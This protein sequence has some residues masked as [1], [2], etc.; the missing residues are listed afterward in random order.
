M[1]AARTEMPLRPGRSKAAEGAIV[2]SPFSMSRS[3]SIVRDVDRHRLGRAVARPIGA[4]DGNGIGPT[5]SVSGAL[6]TQIHGQ[7]PGDLPIGTCGSVARAV[8]R[9]VAGDGR[10]VA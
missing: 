9:L 10:D 2:R 5:A 7:R 1:G 8:D 4:L 3:A 6:G